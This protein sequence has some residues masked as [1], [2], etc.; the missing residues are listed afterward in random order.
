E[1]AV[2]V[3]AGNTGALM[4][5]AM[6]QLRTLPGID[7]PAIAAIWPT[8]RGETV[9]LACGANVDCS[10]G[11]LVD[12][13]AMGAAFA[14]A[15]CGLKQHTVALLNGGS[16]EI[17]GDEQVKG[18]AQILRGVDLP[19]RFHGFVEGDDIG[20]GTV[21]VVVTDGFT[22][23]VALKTAEGTAKLVAH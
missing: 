10:A 3:S 6:F 17:K 9:V 13:A 11:E 1:A 4:A 14:Q 19:M 20:A 15:V 2:A 5:I 23:N 12:F 18:A 7:R 16:E 8:L 21:D 22:G